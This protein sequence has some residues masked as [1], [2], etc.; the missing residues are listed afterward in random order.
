MSILDVSK[1]KNSYIT[2]ILN[3][4]CVDDLKTPLAFSYIFV[5]NLG[6]T[7]FRKGV[8]GRLISPEGWGFG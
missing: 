7:N 4:K 8:F 3:K 2:S 6:K 5:A 1:C